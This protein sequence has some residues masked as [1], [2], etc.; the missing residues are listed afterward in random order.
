MVVLRL[1]AAALVCTV[2]VPFTWVTLPA[3]AE[4]TARHLTGTVSGS[5]FVVDLPADWNGTL[6]LW[7]HGYSDPSQ[8]APPPVPA[9]PLF[10]GWLL[11]HG[12]ALAGSAFPNL[13]WASHDAI[14]DQLALLDWF[15]ANIGKPRRTI[16][17]GQ[18]LG[19]QVTTVLAERYPHRFSAALPMCGPLAG[20]VAWFN[21]MLDVSFTLKTLLWPDQQVQVVRIA[22]PAG[23]QDLANSLLREAL[24]TP[25][26]QARLALANAFGDVPGWADSLAPRPADPGEQVVHQYLYDRYQLGTFLFGAARAQAESALG[27]NPSWN[28]GVD[29]AQQL[30]KSSQRDEVTELYRRAGLDLDADLTTLA[31]APRIGPD[32]RALAG[33]AVDSTI[34]GLPSVPTLTLHTTGD[35]TTVV[36]AERWYG[37]RAAAFGRSANLRQTYVER[38]NHCF[39]TIAEQLAAITAVRSRVDSGK[40]GDTGPAALNAVANSYGPEYRQIWSYYS[41]GSAVAGGAFVDARPGPFPRPFPF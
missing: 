19:A 10:T 20:G 13:P 31:R 35:G 16:A 18:S 15:T 12:Y 5:P 27:G 38:G 4:P 23:N 41:P 30:A 24:N 22:N 3:Q 26:G 33:L 39:F 40:W 32:A 21:G 14:E 2:A 25:E 8:P 36:E 17:V 9:D 29:Y 6:L 1:A 11:D 34:V 7:S 37:D 28:T